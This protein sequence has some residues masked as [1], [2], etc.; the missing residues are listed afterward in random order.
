[1]HPN[2]GSVVS[3][4][5]VQALKGEDISIYGDGSQTRSFCY[6]EDM[7]EGIINMMNT[8]PGLTGPINLGNSN[9][10]SIYELAEL[11]IEITESKSEIVNKPLPQDDPVRRRPDISLAKKELKWHPKVGLAEGLANTID[12]FK[13][14]L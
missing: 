13:K 1:M 10:K 12:Y 7:I 8:K 3:N 11:I 5:I 2:D 14:V 4:F 9:E 6:V